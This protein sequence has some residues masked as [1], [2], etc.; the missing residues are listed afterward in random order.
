MD[1]LTCKFLV[2][3]LAEIYK[4]FPH[5]AVKIESLW[6][7]KRGH[8]YL[9]SLLVKSRPERHGFPLDVYE[10]LLNIYVLHS[11]QAGDFGEPL[12]LQKMNVDSSIPCEL[13]DHCSNKA[14]KVFKC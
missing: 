13:K 8:D 10:I 3:N 1:E 2:Y 6:G 11:T 4:L 12:I 9:K 7:T 14:S 5:V